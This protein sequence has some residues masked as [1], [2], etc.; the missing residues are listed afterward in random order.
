L[1]VCPE[2][3]AVQ[4]DGWTTR[5]ATAAAADP[6]NKQLQLDLT[7]AVG[8]WRALQ[9]KLWRSGRRTGRLPMPRP[10]PF[11]GPGGARPRRSPTQR[12]LTIYGSELAA[13]LLTTRRQAAL[14]YGELARK[15]PK[16]CW[17][18]SRR[19]SLSA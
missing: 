8:R 15:R 14:A 11:F 1:T 5:R 3:L 4:L 12:D 9:R 7:F 10:S 19:T 6:T 17:S 16:S 18:R 2:A 13:I